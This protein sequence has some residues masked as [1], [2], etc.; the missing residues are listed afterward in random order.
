MPNSQVNKSTKE[1]VG[2]SYLTDYQCTPDT[3]NKAPSEQIFY[4]VRAYIAHI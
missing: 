4:I 1:C 2:Q 3:R